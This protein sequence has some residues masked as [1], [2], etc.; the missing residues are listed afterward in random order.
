M[1]YHPH[2]DTTT[3]TLHYRHFVISALPSPLSP[4]VT[5]A[6]PI[7]GNSFSPTGPTLRQ[8]LS[9]HRRRLLT[10][11]EVDWLTASLSVLPRFVFFFIWT[12]HCLRTVPTACKILRKYVAKNRLC[13]RR[14]LL[15]SSVLAY[16]T[17]ATAFLNSAIFVDSLSFSSRHI[18]RNQSR[19]QTLG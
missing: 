2:T 9:S 5:S 17:N 15:K 10:S 16:R 13:S 14:S 6:L 19:T 11:S 18:E 12:K 3:S 1:Y 8:S 4:T 7:P